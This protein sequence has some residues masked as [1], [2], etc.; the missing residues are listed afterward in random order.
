MRLAGSLVVAGIL[1]ISAPSCAGT[2]DCATFPGDRAKFACYDNVSR[3][4]K[5]EPEAAKPAAAKARPAL[6]IGK[7]GRER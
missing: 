7:T 6:N 5:P 2:P 4:P 3:A 1:A